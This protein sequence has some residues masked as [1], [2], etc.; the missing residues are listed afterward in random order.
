M[1]ASVVWMRTAFPS[2]EKPKFPARRILLLQA[3]VVLFGGLLAYGF[4]GGRSAALATLYGG[5]IAM[6]NA[7]LLLWRMHRAGMHKCR[8]RHDCMDAGGRATQGAVAEDAGSDPRAGV[9][10]QQDLRLIYRTGFERLLLAGVLLALGMGPLKL[11]PFAVV[12]GFVLG[13]CAWLVAVAV[14]GAG[15]VKG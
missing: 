5:L 11:D 14:G 7:G 3:A 4:F 8:Q 10:A 15:R 1:F 2:A 6:L 13:Q 9:N 12:A